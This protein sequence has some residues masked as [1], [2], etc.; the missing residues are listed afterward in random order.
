MLK[1]GGG[2]AVKGA[3]RGGKAGGRGGGVAGGRKKEEEEDT[4]PPLSVNDNKAARIKDEERLKSLKWN[5]TAPREEFIEQL[6]TQVSSLFCRFQ[7]SIFYL[8]HFVI[9]SCPKW[10]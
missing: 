9:T 3:T 2:K 10:F 8:S 4:E 6:K 1:G 5:F 7:Y